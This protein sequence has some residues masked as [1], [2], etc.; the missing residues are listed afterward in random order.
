MQGASGIGKEVKLFVA[1]VAPKEEGQRDCKVRDWLSMCPNWETG[2][3]T[4]RP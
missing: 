1:V 4:L 2:K 3:R